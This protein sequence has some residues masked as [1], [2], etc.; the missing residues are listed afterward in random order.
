MNEKE[1]FLVGPASDTYV[2]YLIFKMYA[3]IFDASDEEQEAGKE[4]VRDE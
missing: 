1:K 4:A 3:D 2:V